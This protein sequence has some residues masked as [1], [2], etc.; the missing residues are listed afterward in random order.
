MEYFFYFQI[1]D[2][3][4]S[5]LVTLCR[6][7]DSTKSIEFLTSLAW[8]RASFGGRREVLQARANV[9]S[10]RGL[11]DGPAQKRDGFH[12]QGKMEESSSCT[13]Y[14]DLDTYFYA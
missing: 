3:L 6:S 13:S 7:T 1:E 11:F 4:C 10:R 5:F 14:F 8:W 2:M 9:A 12:A